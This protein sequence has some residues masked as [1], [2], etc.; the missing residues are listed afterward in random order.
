MSTDPSN[1]RWRK[2]RASQ[3]NGSCVEVASASTSIAVRDTKDRQ[4]GMLTIPKAEWTAF[5][6]TLTK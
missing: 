5:L 4:A 1:L 3:S 6:A 2:A